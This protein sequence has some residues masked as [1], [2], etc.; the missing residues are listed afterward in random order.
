MIIK[1]SQLVFLFNFIQFFINRSWKKYIK[2]TV[3]THFS[4]V[5]NRLFGCIRINVSHSRTRN[6]QKKKN[7][8]NKYGSHC[9]ALTILLIIIIFSIIPIYIC[10]QQHAIKDEITKIAFDVTFSSIRVSRIVIWLI[11][12]VT[13]KRMISSWIHKIWECIAR[14]RPKLVMPRLK[15]ENIG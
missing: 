5:S 3:F 11:I 4:R 13:K 12:S 6:C 8:Q 1:L 7:A 9:H 14:R 10:T 2:P 15:I